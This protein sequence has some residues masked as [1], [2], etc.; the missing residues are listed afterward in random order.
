M[1]GSGKMGVAPML[2]AVAIA[3]ASAGAL[4][5]PK[6]TDAAV[7][8]THVESELA[9]HQFES[10]D[11]QERELRDPNVRLLGGN[12]QLYHFYGALG[13]Y[14]TSNLFSCRSQLPFAQKR[15]LLEQWLVAMPQSIAAHIAASQ[16]WSN[17]G[18]TARGDSY[19][20][21]V[22]QEQ[23][24]LMEI[25]R[26]ER[27]PRHTLDQLYA[28]AVRGYPTYFHYY[29]QRAN[30]LQERWYGRPGELRTYAGSLL[31]SP[32]SDAGLV[33]YSYVSYNLMQFNQRSTLLQTTGMSWPVIKSAY[34]TR[35]RLYG[36]RNR[37]WNA[38]C[39]LSLA[40]ID[41]DTA[42]LA[43][44]KIGG[45]WDPAVWKELKYFEEAV[46]WTMGTH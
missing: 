20:D 10:L 38:L 13:G 22:T 6:D 14:S 16:F 5:F 36:L 28:S 32:G 45:N 29:S 41:R 25:A 3:F 42:K 4:A 37:D 19:S 8:C 1:N 12:S 31:Q 26:G 7:V 9:A 30:M 2:F 17:A 18:W 33:A 23:W 21:K 27:N 39:N 24:Q 35:D 44:E 34:A 15:Q 43:L 11:A 40:A 46:S